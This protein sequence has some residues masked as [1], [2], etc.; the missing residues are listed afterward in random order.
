MHFFLDSSFGRPLGTLISYLQRRS[1]AYIV[2]RHTLLIMSSPVVRT[3]EVGILLMS[4]FKE[5][6]GYTA[7]SA[8]GRMKMRQIVKQNK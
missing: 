1:E 3:V 8:E 5:E 2:K 4:Y 6:S 7:A